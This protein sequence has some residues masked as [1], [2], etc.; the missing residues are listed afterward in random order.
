M[1]F[2]FSLFILFFSTVGFAEQFA[3]QIVSP[4]LSYEVLVSVAPYK[5]FVEK[6]AGD[7]V[8]VRLMVPAGASSH[9]FEPTAKQMLEATK[10]DI[11][12][13]IGESFEQRAIQALQS[14]AH[15]MDFVDLRK[16]LKLI[17]KSSETIEDS[18]V[19]F[20]HHCHAHCADLHVWLSPT[21]AKIEAKTIAEALER[22]YP[23]NKEKYQQQL[24]LFL[25]ELDD[26]DR[27]IQQILQPLHN[28]IIMVS[29][30]AYNYFARDYHLK[31]L[32]IE[33][34]GKDPTPQQLTSVLTQARA[35][36]I[37]TIFIQQ[38]YS[39]KG[40]YLIAKNIG[41]RIV[42]LDPYSENYIESMRTIA[43]SFAA[44]QGKMGNY[45]THN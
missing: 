14:H 36:N 39:S 38:Q 30:P 6:I 28:R 7:T 5:F 19:H 25:V 33:F 22:I 17:T 24:K 40:A 11:W 23:E 2:F 9:T 37:K 1:L 10:A 34:E 21:L 4:Q 32:S 15:Q 41:A 43:K 29:H 26:L 18:E 35:Q 8:K 42:I 27:E 44:Q 3:E 16:D 45:G 12:F 20:Y 31:Q 13:Y